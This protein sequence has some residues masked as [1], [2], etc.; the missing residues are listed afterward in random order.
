MELLDHMV[1]LVLI[2][3]GTSI[4]F[5]IVA[6]PRYIPPTVPE[7]SLFSTSSPTFVIFCLFDNSLL[8]GMG[9]YSLVF[10][11]QTVLSLTDIYDAHPVG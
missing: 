2:F 9:Q 4:L 6:A 8:T 3:C 10:R 11:K 1:V 5:S 7:G